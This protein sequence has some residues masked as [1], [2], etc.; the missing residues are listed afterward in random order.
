MQHDSIERQV[1]IEAS[2]E[3]V[4]DVLSKPEHLSE[5]WPDDADLPGG[6]GWITFGDLAEGK[7]E[8]LTIVDGVRP[9][10]FSF[11]WTHPTARPP[12][13]AT[14][15]WSSSRWSRWTVARCCG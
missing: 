4:Y 5:W 13:P 12:R 14:R 15:S 8:R 9:S 10:T 6:D 7:R 1:H 11:R 3:A 2:P